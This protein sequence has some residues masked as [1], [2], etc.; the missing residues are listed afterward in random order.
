MTYARLPAHTANLPTCKPTL[1][2]PTCLPAAS[3]A[4]Q[5]LL[6]K[7][8]WL[9][10]DGATAYQLLDE[11]FV[12][13]MLQPVYESFLPSYGYLMWLNSPVHEAHCCAA[14]WGGDKTVSHIVI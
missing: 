4:G 7:G 9:D 14:R 13:E 11:G 12:T 1:S 2:T 6:N 8:K 5:V 3:T 10:A